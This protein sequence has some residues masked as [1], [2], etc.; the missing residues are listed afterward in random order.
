MYALYPNTY[1]G[2]MKPK[3]IAL[4]RLYAQKLVNSSFLSPVDVVSHMAAMQAQNFRAA[5]WAIGA[6]SPSVIE[7]DVINALDSGKIVRSWPMRGTLHFTTPRD[8]RLLLSLTS[9]RTLKSVATRY[10]RLELDAST[11]RKA[12]RVA[13]KLLQQQRRASRTEFMEA[14]KAAGISVAGQR[15][16]HIILDLAQK[17]V[18]CWGPTE[19]H[20]QALVLMD[21]WI[22]GTRLP[23]R[24]DALAEVVLRYFLGHGPATIKDFAWWTK[25]TLADAKAGLAVV[26]DQL[27]EVQCNGNSYWMAPE[28]LDVDLRAAKAAV[29]MLPSFDEI[30]LGYQDRSASVAAEFKSKIIPDGGGMFLP[31]VVAGGDI[32]GTWRRDDTK[33]RVMIHTTFFREPAKQVT[34]GLP[35]AARAM[36]KF[37]G[38]TVAIA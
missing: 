5:K 12:E 16:I 22:A 36:G 30:L 37:L 18:V 6:R 4:L 25:L 35:A 10:H 14:L 1:D 19:K 8:L 9:A 27:A 20:E 11:L 23:G 33:S 2:N 7:R 38:T 26:R 24:E 21:E 31:S 13:V 17:S 34:R 15:G 3:E 28:L 29:L 32:V